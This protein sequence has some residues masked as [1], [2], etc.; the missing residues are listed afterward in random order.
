VEW[1]GRRGVRARG[2][3]R[4][5]GG[6][7]EQVL[8]AGSLHRLPVRLLRCAPL[9]GAPHRSRVLAA[10]GGDRP[11]GLLGLH[12]RL[13]NGGG[14]PPDGRSGGASRGVRARAARALPLHREAQ[15]RGA[16]RV[17]DLPARLRRGSPLPGVPRR[18][19]VR[20]SGHPRLFIARE[21][22]VAV[23]RLR[24][25]LLLCGSRRRGERVQ[26]LALVPA[27]PGW[28]LGS[29]PVHAPGKGPPVAADVAVPADTTA[30]GG[31][32]RTRRRGGQGPR[33]PTWR[34]RDRGLEH[35]T[36]GHMLRFIDLS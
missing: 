34:C 20:A 14:H 12:L 27:V 8:R 6:G 18:R 33:D 11:E 25:H 32:R 19:R 29:L 28:R 22:G 24:L 30:G 35:F 15:S 1:R 3:A 7:G 5:L 26:R 13:W 23:S 16:V 21:H 17:H 4:L 9:P 31:G 10:G 2:P 36:L